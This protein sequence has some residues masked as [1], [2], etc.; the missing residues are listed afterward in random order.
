MNI[1]NLYQING[2]VFKE[3]VYT[4]IDELKEKLNKILE[5]YNC[6]SYIQLIINETFIN[7][8]NEENNFN[9]YKINNLEE[10]ND[11]DIIQ[12][13][14]ISK[15]LLFIENNNNNFEFNTKYKYDNYYKLLNIIFN[16]EN[17][18]DFI[19]NNSYK[20]IILNLVS[21]KPNVLQYASIAMRN[22]HDIVLSAINSP[23]TLDEK[24]Y[25]V[26]PSKLLDTTATSEDYDILLCGI[27]SPLLSGGLCY[28]NL[29]FKNNKKIV[30]QAV[31][32][33]GLSL[34]YASNRLKNNKDIVLAAVK[35]NGYALY[36]AGINVKNDKDI[37]LA[38]TNQ[39]TNQ[40]Y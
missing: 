14:F 11:N 28:S 2:K 13:V 17:N 29:R 8:G 7:D 27:N 6:D 9:F 5:I 36:F 31:I 1:I 38:A 22:D 39:D 16:I 24:R 12:V 25:S 35:Q 34:Y 4:N 10:L 30:L 19:M 21:I 32:K 15:K 20:T 26:K 40:T 37:I 23:V 33:R 18:F 3:I